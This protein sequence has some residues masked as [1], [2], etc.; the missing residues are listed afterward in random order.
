MSML[1][2][3]IRKKIMFLT[4]DGRGLAKKMKNMHIL[5]RLISEQKI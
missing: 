3:K 4:A 5:R 2:L 1:E